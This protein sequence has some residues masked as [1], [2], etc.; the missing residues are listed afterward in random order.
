MIRPERDR[1]LPARALAILLGASALVVATAAPAIAAD[2]TVSTIGALQ[3]ALADCAT[4]PNTITLTGPISATGDT[5]TVSCDT[6]IDLATFDLAVRNVI[7]AAGVEL[8][9]TGPTDGTEG[10]FTVNATGVGNIAAIRTTGATLRVTGG[11]VH[12]IS[13]SNGAAIGGATNGSGGTLLVEAGD[14]VAEALSSGYAAAIGGGYGTST[15]SDGGIITVSGGTLTAHSSGAYN[16]AIGGGGGGITA[17]TQGAGATLTVT[18]GVVRAIADGSASVAI[19]GGAW[20]LNGP[21]GGAGGSLTIGAGGTVIASSPRT[22]IGGGYGFDPYPNGAFGTVSVAGTLSLPSGA[23]DV[24][25]SGAGAEITVTSTGSIIGGIATPTTGATITGAGQIANAG[26]IGLAP[27]ASMVTGNNRLLTFSTSAPSVRV[28]APTT[29]SGYRSLATPTVGTAWNTASD[30]SGSW[31]TS[32]SSTSGSG[33]TALYAVAPGSLEVSTDAAELT[34]TAGE[35]FS[36]PVTVLGPDGDPLTPQ[37]TVASTSPDCTFSGTG[38]FETAGTCTIEAS[39]TV[40]GVDLTTTFDIE[41]VAGAATALTVTPSAATVP[42][43]GSLT[44]VVTGEDAY[45][46]PTTTSGVVLT[47]SVA[48]DVVNGLT[49]SFPHASPH[50]ITATLGA[51]IGSVTVQVQPAAVVTPPALGSTGVDSAGMLTLGAGALALLAAGVVLLVVRR[52]RHSG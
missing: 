3:S 40:Q 43:G 38:V 4:E 21:S 34:A 7:I 10:T 8:E 11:A 44:F 36:F 42:Q 22:A 9:V 2:T 17:G 1:R 41:V 49:V 27:P 46:N 48:T 18:G 26:V 47:S 13:G 35:P 6:T 12:A 32:T 20:P 29:A 24:P 31:F 33:T 50:T 19:G 5:L 52:R 37:P 39:V 28:F 15:A 45:G 25:D 23:L 16:T 51:A 30:G 14:V